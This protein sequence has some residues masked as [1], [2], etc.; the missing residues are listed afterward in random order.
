LL[1]AF[2]QTAVKIT[3]DPKANE[4][5]IPPKPK[6]RIKKLNDSAKEM[7]S[8]RNQLGMSQ[9]DFAIS[10]GESRDKIINIENGRL[11][12]VPLELL[13]RAREMIESEQTLRVEPLKHLEAMPMPALVDRWKTMIGAEDDKETAILLGTTLTTIE[14]WKTGGVRPA[15]NSLLRYEL[16]AKRVQMRRAEG[17]C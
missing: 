6:R 11:I 2:M 12:R 15:S 3:I 9:P 5:S 13:N 16:I 17:T 10:L 8:I 7:L 4:S 14:R 1:D